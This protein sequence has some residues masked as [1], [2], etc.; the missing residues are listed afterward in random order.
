VPTLVVHGERDTVPLEGSRAWAAR[1]NARLLVIAGTGHA[2]FVER[3]EVFF[4]AVDQFLRGEWPD[5]SQ[6]TR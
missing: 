6:M 4:P 2:S 1:L 3:P 5:D